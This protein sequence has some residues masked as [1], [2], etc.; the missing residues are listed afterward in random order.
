MNI[1]EFENGLKTVASMDKRER[2][3]IILSSIRSQ[4][5]RLKCVIVTEELAELQQQ[6]SK[7]LRETGSK[8]ELLEEIADVYIC[9]EFLKSIFMINEETFQKA[10]DVK[11]ERERRRCESIE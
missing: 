2:Q 10:V 1:N 11:L 5:W 7:Q 4:P 6:I 9:L 3:D 8:N